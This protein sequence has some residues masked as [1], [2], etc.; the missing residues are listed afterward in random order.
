MN[1]KPE[2]TKNILDNPQASGKWVAE[3]QSEI[4]YEP[5]QSAMLSAE[6]KYLSILHFA[7]VG[8]YQ[9]TPEGA[10]LFANTRFAAMLGFDSADELIEWNNSGGSK[11]LG[12]TSDW[13]TLIKLLEQGSE[14]A[15]VETQL[16]RMDDSCMWVAISARAVR[17]DDGGL[18]YIDGFALDVT[19]RKRAE[20]NLS[21]SR[22]Q[23]RNLARRQEQAR[24]DER[25]RIAREIHDEL[26]QLITVLHMDLN[27]LSSKFDPND[28][29]IQD[30]TTAMA[31]TVGLIQ[32]TVRRIAAELRP[33]MLDDLGLTA[34]VEWLA[35]EFQN[36]TG[37]ACDLRIEPPDIDLDRD[38]ATALFRIAQEA[39]TNIMRHA[40]A[41]EVCIELT[42]EDGQMHLKVQDN[43]RGITREKMD[44]A[45]SL[46]I[47]GIRERVHFLGGRVAIK[48]GS[49]GTIVE[50]RLPLS[51]NE[52]SS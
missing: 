43:G 31:G 8:V 48:G 25:T 22:E 4:V 17:D 14:N 15:Q 52:A 16:Q 44:D 10:L 29:E 51:G 11:M 12:C 46:G 32:Q 36:R 47:I 45:G 28:S 18:L 1:K 13:S 41:T 20:K 5:A 37:I 24:E 6:K 19:E 2:N 34:A 38:R 49:E 40:E 35:K 26:G 21:R 23:L 39:L 3:L 30:K 33:G 9:A 7:P 42:L 27:W 50:V